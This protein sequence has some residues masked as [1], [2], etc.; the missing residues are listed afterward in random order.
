MT[1]SL[2][3]RVENESKAAGL[4]LT[5]LQTCGRPGALGDDHVVGHLGPM[6]V[7]FVRDRGQDWMEIGPADAEPRCFF[8]FQDVQFALGWK[9]IDQV[10][11]MKDVEPLGQVL[12]LVADR[13]SEL[14]RHLS[15]GVA[16]A[17]WK[18]VERAADARGEAFA[19]RLR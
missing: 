18:R 10:L 6:L 3:Q 12:Q 9:S 7:R 17:G 5:N 19:E 16:S 8:S 2:F 4:T 15:G 13:W 11:D 1:R 14:V